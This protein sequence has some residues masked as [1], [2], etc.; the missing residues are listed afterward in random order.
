MRQI[1][2]EAIISKISWKSICSALHI[3]MVHLGTQDAC[4]KKVPFNSMKNRPPSDMQNMFVATWT[5]KAG[6]VS[7]G[8]VPYGNL[9]MPPAAQ[10]LNYGQAL[11]EGMKALR[12]ANDEIVLFRPL[13]NAKRMVRGA[14]RMVMEPLPP[15]F[16]LQAVVDL[17]T[18]NSSHVRVLPLPS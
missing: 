14:Q 12:T 1:D 13:E 8:V 4:H 9:S 11:F 16:F 17:V 10:V 18:A 6:W 5:E 15:A 7:K 2:F 3:H